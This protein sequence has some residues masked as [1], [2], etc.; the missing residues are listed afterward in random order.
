MLNE[1]VLTEKTIK[2]GVEQLKQEFVLPTPG[3][4]EAVLRRFM[5]RMGEP[6]IRASV[7]GK[8]QRP[9]TSPMKSLPQVERRLIAA[10]QEMT[11]AEE[12]RVLA[13]LEAL[14]RQDAVAGIQFEYA[15]WRPEVLALI[16]KPWFLNSV[17]LAYDESMTG[18]DEEAVWVGP[19]DSQRALIAEE[20]LFLQLEQQQRALWERR[21]KALE[22][23]GVKV[24]EP[25]A[26]REFNPTWHRSQA[27]I[28]D[29]GRDLAVR[30]Q[31]PDQALPPFLGLSEK[32]ARRLRQQFERTGMGTELFG[33]YDFSDRENEEELVQAL[34]TA[35]P[36]ARL[37]AAT[38]IM[39]RARLLY[40]DTPEEEAA[41]LLGLAAMLGHA[42]C[43]LAAGE[44]GDLTQ[45]AWAAG[46]E[47]ILTLY[48]GDNARWD[49]VFPNYPFILNLN[50]FA[51]EQLP[52]M[53]A[54]ATHALLTK[55]IEEA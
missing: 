46:T 42:K 52:A 36:D 34:R 12:L 55:R 20:G 5:A 49:G 26:M 29:T 16:G 13:A 33:V 1:D 25:G 27:Q 17:K 23:Q 21:A 11:L 48:A 32:R 45:L 10:Q 35:L 41:G 38:E 14:K 28:W 15:T 39:D 2:D 47:A 44:L 22:A 18:R 37:Y 54:Q 30:F 31:V 6:K 40:R 9:G 53:L 7:R 3:E 43:F 24:P 4:K 50:R 8:Q 51:P 19:V